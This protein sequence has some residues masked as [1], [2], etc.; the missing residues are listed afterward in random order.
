MIINKNKSKTVLI[1]DDDKSIREIFSLIVKNWGI[2]VITA[3]DGKEA[4]DIAKNK[5]PHLILLDVKMP[6]I[7][8]YNVCKILKSKRKT[9]K[10]PIILLTGLSEL[11]DVK[12]GYHYGADDYFIKPVKWD[13]FKFKILKLLNFKF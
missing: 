4:I 5:K 12:K 6:K 2:N 1:A 13:H 7:D 10:I 8:G 11:K 9:K 3:Q